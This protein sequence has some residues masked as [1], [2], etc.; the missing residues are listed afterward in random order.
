MNE[1]LYEGLLAEFET[2][3]A[4]L[5]ALR[6]LYA[7]GY[8]R[9]D[10]Y[11]PYPVAGAEEALGL[12]RSRLP[13]AV[14]LGGLLGLAGSYWIQWYCNAVSYPVNEGGRPGHSPAAF[15]PASFETTILF[16]ALVAFFGALVLCRLP[17]LWHPVFEVEGFERASID[18][19]FVGIDARD[20]RFDVTLSARSLERAKPL[21]I[22]R[23]T[24]AEGVTPVVVAGE[25]GRPS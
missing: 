18:R 11:S 5:D 2:A 14:F 8:R 4:M 19:F 9:L 15:V 25:A 24:E 7:L 22:V 20:P 1:I 17:K 21:R 3:D 16:S 12:G 10:A 13:W 6:A 23:L